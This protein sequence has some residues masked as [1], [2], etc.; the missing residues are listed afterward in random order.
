MLWVVLWDLD[1]AV[2]RK[3]DERARIINGDHSPNKIRGGELNAV[4][5]CRGITAELAASCLSKLFTMFIPKPSDAL[6]SDP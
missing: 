5:F 4:A 3:S 1:L 2:V 6:T